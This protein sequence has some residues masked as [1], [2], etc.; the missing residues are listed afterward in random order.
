VCW[1]GDPH[2]HRNAAQALARIRQPC[3]KLLAADAGGYLDSQSSSACDVTQGALG[4]VV[5]SACL[6]PGRESHLQCSSIDSAPPA[7]SAL[8]SLSMKTST[9]GRSQAEACT[10]NETSVCRNGTIAAVREDDGLASSEPHQHSIHGI[11]VYRWLDSA[12]GGGKWSE[13]Q[14]A[15]SDSSELTIMVNGSS[16]LCICSF[17]SHV[18]IQYCC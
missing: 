4:S 5:R 17:V 16:F 2:C 11:Q 14:R 12:D 1:G 18:S 15:S 10:W 3:K 6:Y 8:E 13:E 7:T 9:C